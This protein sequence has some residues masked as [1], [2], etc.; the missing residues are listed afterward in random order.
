M[1]PGLDSL[2]GFEVIEY[3][4]GNQRREDFVTIKAN[5]TYSEPSVNNTYPFDAT[6]II[7]TNSAKLTIKGVPGNYKKILI[8]LMIICFLLEKLVSS[9]SFGFYSIISFF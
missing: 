5:G 1:Q 6:I 9:T 2:I 8:I 4:R 7:N 3:D